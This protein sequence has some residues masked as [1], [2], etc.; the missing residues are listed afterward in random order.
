MQPFRPE[1]A[2]WSAEPDSIPPMS[3][4]R[5]RP[6]RVLP[7]RHRRGLLRRGL[8][9]DPRGRVCGAVLVPGL[10]RVSSTVRCW[11]AGGGA[12]AGRTRGGRL[13]RLGLRPSVLDARRCA[14]RYT[15]LGPLLHQHTSDFILH[16]L[17]LNNIR[18]SWPLR[19]VSV[20]QVPTELSELLRIVGGHLWHRTPGDLLHQRLD[21]LGV[22]GHAQGGHLVN[23]APQGPDVAAERVRLL[24]ADLG[25]EVVG[26]TD[27]RPRECCGVLQHLGDAEVAHPQ[28]VGGREEQVLALE[29]AVED[30]LVV[31]VLQRQGPLGEPPQN[32]A[33]LEGLPG[34]PGR[35]DPLVQVPAVRVVHNDGQGVVLGEAL[36][37]AHNVW[38]LEA[39]EYSHLVDGV[40]PLFLVHGAHVD[41]LHHIELALMVLHQCGLAVATLANVLDPDVAMAGSGGGSPLFSPLL[42]R[43]GGL[44][45]HRRRPTGPAG[46]RQ[47]GPRGPPGSAAPA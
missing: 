14:G 12:G 40:S 8:G 4:G 20:Q 47:G 26:R 27:G 36:A 13:G 16:V 39:R 35:A 18:G 28:P 2:R 38:V 43:C 22:E 7:L 6:A 15:R 11:P 23:H 33:L 19:H 5:P 29:V 41:G 46:R 1:S 17:P 10:L 24:L 45:V 31:H 37:I 21:V 44:R 25:T 30:V 3:T 32:L 34:L 9:V 42:R